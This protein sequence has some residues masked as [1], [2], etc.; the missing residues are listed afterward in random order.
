M[1]LDSCQNIAHCSAQTEHAHLVWG[2]VP[3][4]AMLSG[5]PDPF[6]PFKQL[7]TITRLSSRMLHVARWCAVQ[8]TAHTACVWRA[9][10]AWVV[11]AQMTWLCIYTGNHKGTAQMHNFATSLTTRF[12]Q[13]HVKH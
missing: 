6:V 2:P 10:V 11:H 8:S 5:A 1:H 9:K 7:K 13:R 4:A 3:P 12:K